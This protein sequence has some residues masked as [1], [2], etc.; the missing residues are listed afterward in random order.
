MRDEVFTVARIQVVVSCIKTPCGM[1]GDYQHSRVTYN[2]K[3][4][5]YLFQKY[6]NHLTRAHYDMSSCHYAWL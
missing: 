5:Q 6:H 4:E 3:M 2:L 1:V